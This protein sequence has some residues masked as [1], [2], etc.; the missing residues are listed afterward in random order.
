MLQP[1][2]DPSSVSAGSDLTSVGGGRF[3][4]VPFAHDIIAALLPGQ[5][6][7]DAL[8]PHIRNLSP[9]GVKRILVSGGAGFVGSHLVDK[10]LLMGH[11]VI[12]L[13]NFYTGSADNLKHW[14]GYSK[15]RIV[16]HDVT[17]PFFADVDQIYH[18]ACPA[19]PPQYQRDPIFTINTCT[20]GTLNMLKLAKEM[21]ARVLVA[22]TSEVYGDPLEHPQN[23]SYWG[24][25]N[26]I[27]PRAC[28]DEGKRISETLSYA[29]AQSENVDV[30]V[31]RIFN[32]FG[33]RMNPQDGRVVSN[34]IVQA[35]RGESLTLY[36]DGEQTRCFQ[37]VPDL[38]DG[39]IAVMEGK[40]SEPI[41]LGNPDEY[42]V[43][44]LAEII[45]SSVNKDIDIVQLPATMDDPQRRRP[46]ISRAKKEVGWQPRFSMQHG[47]HQTVEF[48]AKIP[49]SAKAL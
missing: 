27:G 39:L 38:V 4:P 18:L 21:S 30:R 26:P 7:L 2:S 49:L 32:T 11:S 48:F 12:V 13:D 10:L 15:L 14:T 17:T 20:T 9:A 40:C 41:N 25:V 19:S 1:A 16:D 5:N 37:Y 33:P 28:Y 44:A 3:A 23:E 6:A 22:S 42:T 47:L 45:R 35:L 43:R 24:H 46:D 31:V 36:G 34:F 8:R 29:F